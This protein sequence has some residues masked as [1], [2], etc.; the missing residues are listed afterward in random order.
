MYPVDGAFDSQ[1]EEIFAD[2]DVSK[3]AQGKYIVYV[4]S[5]ERNNKWGDAAS[6]AYTLDNGN[7]MVEDNKKSSMGSLPLLGIQAA[8]LV[9]WYRASSRC[10]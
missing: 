4:E 2:I 5:M 6:L 1:S 9:R 10:S 7:L 3:N 8:F